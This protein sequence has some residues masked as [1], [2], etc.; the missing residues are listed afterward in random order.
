MNTE[1]LSPLPAGWRIL[2]QSMG[3]RA[4][5]Q[6]MPFPAMNSACFSR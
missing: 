3:G 5:T 2:E 4:A 1:A 6:D